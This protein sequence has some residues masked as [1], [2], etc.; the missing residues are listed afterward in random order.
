MAVLDGDPAPCT[1]KVIGDRL[2]KDPTG[3]GPLKAR[4]IQDALAQLVSAGLADSERSGGPTPARWWSLRTPVDV[5][6]TEDA[7]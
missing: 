3:R 7:F 1:V 5:V 2:A 4:T 6:E